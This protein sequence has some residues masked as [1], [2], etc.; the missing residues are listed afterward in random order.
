VLRTTGAQAGVRD[1]H[2]YD[3]PIIGSRLPCKDTQAGVSVLGG[4]C[5]H[6]AEPSLVAVDPYPPAH[7]LDTTPVAGWGNR[8][9]ST[10][11]LVLENL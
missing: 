8:L 1:S 2:Q 6:R 11:R 7:L 10:A 3:G 9:P 5:I 4:I